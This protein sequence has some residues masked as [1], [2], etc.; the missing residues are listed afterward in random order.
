MLVVSTHTEAW[1]LVGSGGGGSV[2][3]NAN[4]LRLLPEGVQALMTGQV[5]VGG[6]RLP[7]PGR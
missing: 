6:G 5:S 3:G 7:P 1:V 2:A 4:A